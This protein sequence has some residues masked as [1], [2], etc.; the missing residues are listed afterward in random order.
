VTIADL[1][2]AVREMRRLQRKYSLCCRSPAV[3]EQL[4]K[5]ELA[6]DLM[7]ADLDENAPRPR[8][9]GDPDPLKEDRP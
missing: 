7:L 9:E 4:R 2:P 1:A 8:G 3:L 5:L 6:V